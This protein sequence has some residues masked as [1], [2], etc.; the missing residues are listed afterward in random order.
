MRREEFMTELAL[1]LQD[2][3]AE[4]R[5]EAMQ[6]YNDYFDDAGKDQE[7]HIVEQL[8]SPAKVAT[9]VKAGLHPQEEETA[10]YRD[11]GYADTRFEYRDSLAE[12]K[13]N[14]HGYEGSHTSVVGKEEKEPW[15][16]KPLKVVLTVLVILAAVPILGPIL[17]GIAAA[18]LGIVA[19]I[20]AVFAALVIGAAAILFAGIGVI[21]AGIITL[22][23]NT[24]T[25]LL[26]MGIGFILSVIGMIGTVAA[27]KLCV[28]VFPGIIRG[29]AHLGRKIVHREKAVN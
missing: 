28:V 7:E 2:I 18:V 4:E 11:T 12:K 22:F 6:Y 26:V 23:T 1:L 25:G 29:I 19:A 20:I 21:V 3:S 15:T 8:G 17:A 10:E 13:D 9:E 14:K 24:A 5:M 27:V 16:N